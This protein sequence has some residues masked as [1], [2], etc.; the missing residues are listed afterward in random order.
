MHRL[1]VGWVPLA[2]VGLGYSIRV[3]QK[4]VSLSQYWKP[5]VHLVDMRHYRY[6]YH[7]FTNRL[8]VISSS[9]SFVPSLSVSLTSGVKPF[10]EL[11]KH[12]PSRSRNSQGQINITRSNIQLFLLLFNIILT[13]HSNHISAS[14]S[15]FDHPSCL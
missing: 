9:C 2:V 7:R 6:K 1:T 11:A 12:C 3:L 15:M 13:H 10:A 8:M 5:K 14:S 4:H